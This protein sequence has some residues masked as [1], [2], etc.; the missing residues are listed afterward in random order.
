MELWDDGARHGAEVP[1]GSL[2][3]KPKDL[4]LLEVDTITPMGSNPIMP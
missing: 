4:A 2:E 1:E 3:D